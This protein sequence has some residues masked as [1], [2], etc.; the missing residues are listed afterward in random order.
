[1]AFLLNLP[2]DFLHLISFRALVCLHEIGVPVEVV[3][4]QEL[5][6]VVLGLLII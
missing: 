5:L 4:Y 3:F 6:Q 1:M 2:L